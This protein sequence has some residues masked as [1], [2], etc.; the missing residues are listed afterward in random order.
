MWWMIGVFAT[1]A[2][3]LGISPVS[4]KSLVPLPAASTIALMEGCPFPGPARAADCHCINY[5]LPDARRN[6]TTPLPRRQAQ[7]TLKALHS[8]EDWRSRRR[9]LRA[10]EHRRADRSRRDRS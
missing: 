3:G 5:I 6:F 7:R 10:F 4:G 1:G 8:L 9:S 2:M